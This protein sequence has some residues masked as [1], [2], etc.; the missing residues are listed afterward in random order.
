MANTLTSQ[1]LKDHATAWAY[2]FT[3]E[4]DGSGDESFVT[5]VTANNLIASTGD[6]SS[7]RLTINKL[8]WSIASGASATQSPIIKLHWSGDAPNTIATLTGSGVFDLVTNGTCPITNEIANTNGNLLISTTGFTNG[9][10]YTI[11]IEGKKTAGYSSRE[12]T[13]DGIA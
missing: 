8:F 5:K 1:K 12:V 4:N 6:G 10:A 3:H 13:D 11:I 2:K 7:Q 9:A